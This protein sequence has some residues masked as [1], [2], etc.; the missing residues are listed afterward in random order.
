MEK[1]NKKIG[2]FSRVK[3]AVAKLENYSLFVEEKTTVAVKYFF[4]IVLILS[5]VIAAVQTFDMV[6]MI[7]KG[8]QYVQNEMPDFSYEEGNLNFAGTVYSYDETYD[9]YMIADTQENIADEILQQYR[10]DIKSSGLIFLKD[11]VIYKRGNSETEYYY[12]DLSTQ[13]GIDSMD[14]TKLIQEIDNIG[15]TGIA[16]TIFLA[17]IVSVYLVQIVS[18]FIDWIVISIF[19]C[20]AAR[21]CRINMRFKHGFNISIYALTLSII[22]S[23]CYQI[24]NYMTGF[25]TEYF[26]VVYLLISYV[27]VVAV[28]LMIKS[29]LLKQQVEVGKIVETQKQIHEEL[30]EPKEKEEE[31]KKENKKPEEKSTTESDENTTKDEPNGSEI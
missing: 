14:K 9:L 21:I 29:D 5:L 18:T 22:L 3:I 10:N 30:Q 2:F 16:I 31:E 12:T 15:T 24:A 25:Y 26:R 6:K 20:I 17:V 23:M 28:I 1:E 13:Y 4:L 7:Q 19:A 27:Y 8:Y 11:K